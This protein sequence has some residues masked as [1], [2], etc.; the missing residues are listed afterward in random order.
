MNPTAARRIPAWTLWLLLAW[1][2]FTPIRALAELPMLPLERKALRNPDA[3]LAELPALKAAAEG[4]SLQLSLLSLA[5]ANACRVVADW[6]CQQAAGENAS[7]YA[8]LAGEAILEARGQIAS[9]RAKIALGD[10]YAGE[11]QLAVAEGLLKPT[12]STDLLADVQ[13]GYSSL[14]HRL[15]KH[16]VAAEYAEKGLATLGPAGDLAMRVRLQRNLARARAALGD[17]EASKRA[18]QEARVLVRDL[19]DPKLLAE[20]ALEE[21]RLAQRERDLDTQR[22]SA[23]EILGLAQQLRNSQLEGLGLELQGQLAV[24]E[25]DLDAARRHFRAATLAFRALNL[26]RDEIRAIDLY[27]SVALDQPDLANWVVRRLQLETQ[28]SDVER[29]RA[30]EGFEERLR[31]A[32]Q[33]LAYVRLQS[34]AALLNAERASTELRTRYDLVVATLAVILLLVMISLAWLQRLANRKLREALSARQRAMLQTSH[35][36][37]NSLVAIRGISERLSQQSLPSAQGEMLHTIVR[38]ADHLA[39]LAQDLLDRGR[40]EAGQLRL[41]PRPTRLSALV[42]QV[43]RLH[44]PLAREKGLNLVLDE[45]L[46]SMQAVEVDVDATRLEQ[47]LTNL[48]ANA[49]KFTDRGSVTLSVQVADT[50]GDRYSTHFSV[51]DS[52]PG[53]AETEIAALFRPF[54]QT[55]LGKQHAS[56][57]GLGL[58]ISH[59]LVALMGGELSVRNV[60]PHG[61]CFAFNLELKACQALRVDESRSQP[62]QPDSG[63]PLRVVAIDDDPVILMIYEGML[64]HLGVKPRLHASLD[65][66]LADADFGRIDLLLLDCEL[67]DGQS[68]D[69]ISLIRRR[70]QPWLRVVVVSGHPAPAQLPDGVDEWVQ[71]PPTSARFAM[72]VAAARR[73]GRPLALT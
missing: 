37:R 16:Q 50:L 62:E 25:G 73:S 61:C 48:I 43:H 28:V 69:R 59:D 44:Q 13:L 22:A 39:A 23:A 2:S 66:A 3:V 11:L 33:E 17:W 40:L 27:L 1:I 63:Q 45:R 29:A 30:A 57:A 53:I 8:R 42:R 10:F 70:A 46:G 14:S 56:G 67:S 21:A 4:D 36:M 52:G 68:T 47:V 12:G 6:N 41:N 54:S 51:T 18:L 58:S 55:S 65:E 20:V 5:E 35:E 34:E 9:A 15:G 64:M 32:Q 31:Y 26:G 72:I 71:K 60:R 19:G 38:G 7:A 24:Q 49:L